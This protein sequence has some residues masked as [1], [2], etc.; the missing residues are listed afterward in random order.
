MGAFHITLIAKN[1]LNSPVLQDYNVIY[2]FL[3]R[4]KE[5]SWVNLIRST[6]LDSLHEASWP[7]YESTNVAFICR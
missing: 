4:K 5:V 6:L 1:I 3:L 7:Y 2:S